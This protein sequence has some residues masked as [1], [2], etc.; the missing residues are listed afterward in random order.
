MVRAHLASEKHAKLFQNADNIAIIDAARSVI[1]TRGLSNMS[2]RVVADHADT[3]VGSISYRIGDRAAL[4]NAVVAREI[5]LIT[6]ATADF[7][8]RL[9]GI[10][11]VTT[12]ILP[13]VVDAWLDLMAGQHRTSAII[14]CELMLLAS[15][16]ANAV[17]DL[18]VLLNLYD[19]MWHDML[20]DASHGAQLA[21]AIACYC[22]DERPFAVALD[23][24]DDYRALRRA[25]THALLDAA[26]TTTRHGHA[27][28]HTDLVR[29]LAIPAA[30]ALEADAV[31][32]QGTRA[33]IADHIA[34]LIRAGGIADLSHRAV[35]QAA[36]L[37]ASSVVHHYPTHH[38]IVLG[39]VEAIYRRMR[40]DGSDPQRS[41]RNVVQLTHECALLANSNPAFIP[42]AI[43][44]RRRRA[45]NVQEHAA[46]WLGLAAYE[47]PARV[48]A[49]TMAVI[50]NCL[51]AFARDIA[52]AAPGDQYRSFDVFD[53]PSQ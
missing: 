45:E 11:P 6:D 5:S 9:H 44:M 12:H 15:R 43:D 32:P 41:I 36:G 1:A 17:P 33:A 46:E 14:I 31:A 3:S 16:T 13:D 10:A 26:D 40:A 38:D 39:G 29:R 21:R 2:L 52:I 50:G 8:A 48:Q 23:G 24:V 25:T 35:A 7:A 22:I 18:P 49:I 47:H 37:A 42:F 53:H 28:W 51:N 20:R 34:D 27:V 4:V 30:P 19:T